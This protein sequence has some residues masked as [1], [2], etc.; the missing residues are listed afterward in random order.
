[1]GRY[2]RLAVNL[3]CLVFPSLA[4]CGRSNITLHDGTITRNLPSYGRRYLLN[5][6]II[7]DTTTLPMYKGNNL[8]CCAM[9]LFIH[10]FTPILN[11]SSHMFKSKNYLR[12]IQSRMTHPS[13]G[14]WS[15]DS[16]LPIFKI[17]ITKYPY[18]ISYHHTGVGILNLDRDSSV[19]IWGINWFEISS[20]NIFGFQLNEKR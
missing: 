17:I 20:K 10:R 14:I 7:S 3:S 2:L 8:L 9:K 12:L 16:R 13:L 6:M 19:D 5:G 1:M 11:G 4:S 15:L 18:E